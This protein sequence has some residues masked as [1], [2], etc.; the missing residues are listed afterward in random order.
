VSVE[1]FGRQ[2]KKE[3]DRKWSHSVN[4][5]ELFEVLVVVD[6][7]RPEYTSLRCRLNSENHK[8]N[9]LL[10]GMTAEQIER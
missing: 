6:S 5:P 2:W 4:V 7:M 1:W 8:S 3:K 9:I 10:L